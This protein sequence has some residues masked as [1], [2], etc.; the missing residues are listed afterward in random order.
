MGFCFREETMGDTIAA[1][2]S[3]I[4]E[5]G[6]GVVR[7]SG[8]KAADIMRK[9]LRPAPQAPVPRHAYYGHAVSQD[10]GRDIDEVICIYMKA[11]N[12]YT[13]ED[14]VEFQSHGSIVSLRMILRSVLAAGARMAEPGEFTKL[15]FLNGRLDLTQAEAVIDLIK[16]KS[17]MPHDI[18]ASQLAGRLGDRVREIR[19]SLL[20]ILAEMAVNIDFPDEDI[21]QIAMDAFRNGLSELLTQTRELLSTADAGKIAKNGIKLVIAG[22]PNVGK[23]SLMNALLGE[24]R[25]IVTDIP[26]TTRDTIEES[27][28]IGGIPFVLTDTAGIRKTEDTIEK[29]GIERSERELKDADL[30]LAVFDGS[31]RLSDEDL[32]IARRTARSNAIAVVNKEDLGLTIEEETLRDIFGQKRVIVTS[33]LAPEGAKEVSDRIET[34]VLGGKVFEKGGAVITSERQRAS[35]ERAAGSLEEAVS[36]IERGESLEICEL[37]AHSAYDFLGEVIGEA[38]GEEIL[39]TVFSRFCLGK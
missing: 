28:S 1:I 3:A 17:E 38:A 30:T 35:L 37:E 5:G 31:E 13:C 39:D 34:L 20:D 8:D 21:E 22:R 11:P 19:A 32:D 2:S 16:A 26:G 12:S 9:V 18:A 36:L 7:V 33:L 24:G 27:L 6:I 25:A 14:V 15:A 10:D 4:G 29:I 23:S